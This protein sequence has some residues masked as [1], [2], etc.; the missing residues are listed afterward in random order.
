MDWESC[1]LSPCPSTRNHYLFLTNILFFCL[2]TTWQEYQ[3][4]PTLQNARNANSCQLEMDRSSGC[5]GCH[6]AQLSQI[7]QNHKITQSGRDCRGH[8]AQSP[9]PGRVSWEAN[10]ELRALSRKV[11]KSSPDGDWTCSNAWLC[12]ENLVKCS[13]P[14]LQQSFQYFLRLPC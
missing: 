1:I 2:S 13:I 11:L 14:S 8:R 3:F 10:T 7:S 9:A 5:Q 12:S 4:H 6:C